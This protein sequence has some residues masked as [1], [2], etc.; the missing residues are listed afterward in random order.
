MLTRVVVPK[1]ECV[2]FHIY[3]SEILRKGEHGEQKK[4]ST[5]RSATI[6][7]KECFIIPQKN[8][9]FLQTANQSTKRQK[10]PVLYLTASKAATKLLRPLKSANSKSDISE[11][12][13]HRPNSRQVKTKTT[14]ASCE[15]AQRATNN[16]L[17]YA[18][19]V[20][21]N[22]NSSTRLE[23]LF[24]SLYC[25]TIRGSEAKKRKTSAQYFCSLTLLVLC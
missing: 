13:G 24:Y 1:P 5:V 22:A 20:G 11:G 21:A 18:G 7:I 19:R 3:I 10:H 15:A 12:G 14:R 2:P 8:C 17:D 6:Y 25:I 23:Y 16:L 4:A 9:G